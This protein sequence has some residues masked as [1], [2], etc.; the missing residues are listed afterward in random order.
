MNFIACGYLVDNIKVG[1]SFEMLKKSGVPG[2]PPQ[3][4]W[5]DPKP[6]QGNSA[7]SLAR[8]FFSDI[9]VITYLIISATRIATSNSSHYSSP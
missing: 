1:N 4:P 9:L 6:V 8:K 7:K 2:I 3:S 5:V